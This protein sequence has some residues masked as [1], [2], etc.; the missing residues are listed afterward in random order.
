MNPRKIPGLI[1]ILL[2][3]V[4]SMP[5]VN[6]LC[7]TRVA[8]DR[9]TSFD[10]QIG[11]LDGGQLNS[12]FFRDGLT[13]DIG[14]I[15]G[16]P[17]FDVRLNFT[18]S[19]PVKEPNFTSITFGNFIAYEGNPV[20]IVSYQAWNRT[21]QAWVTINRIPDIDAFMWFNFT[22]RLA[23][24]QDFIGPSGQSWFRLLHES[25]GNPL[26]VLSID[27]SVLEVTYLVD[28]PDDT[29]FYGRVTN[30]IINDKWISANQSAGF[31]NDTYQ[32]ILQ[33]DGIAF[34]DLTT[35]T[36]LDTANRLDLFGTNQ[37]N[38]T[39]AQPNDDLTRLSK[40]EGAAGIGDYDVTFEMNIT[41]ISN[42]LSPALKFSLFTSSQQLNDYNDI[43]DQTTIL[44][45]SLASTTT[46]TTHLVS[47]RSGGIT[48][49][50]GDNALSVGTH[51]YSRMNKSGTLI[52]FYVYSDPA[53]TTLV[54]TAE[55][56]ATGNDTA[57]YWIFPNVLDFNSGG[58][59]QNSGTLSNLD[60]GMGG[61]GFEYENGVIYST[62]LFENVTSSASIFFL[63][64][65][66]GGD[67]SIT[68]DFSEDNSTWTGAKLL[69]NTTFCA[70]NLEGFAL[71]PLFVRFRLN[72]TN[73]LN[74]PLINSYEVIYPAI[75][76][77]DELDIIWLIGLLWLGLV[78]IGYLKEN[79]ILIMFAGF[80]GLILGFLFFVESGMVAIVL[81]LL[82]LYLL[83]EG[84]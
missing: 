54:H 43:T 37:I 38:F 21:G 6:G 67:T 63:N 19:I 62:D 1:L 33:P 57:R 29:P 41:K 2:V 3:L 55:L 8:F 72:T 76:E 44:L 4:P 16:A 49:D 71:N 30:P 52:G 74:T 73:G 32:L 61:G 65:S 20:H 35:W 82:N 47:T 24:I 26:H 25:A 69:P 22:V 50:I 46:Y 34:E 31:I 53:R 18:V 40:D 84:T 59:Q 12:T 15:A 51:Y 81:I 36:L 56:T 10:I 5:T 70:I 64:Y 58:G 27:Y 17:G 7:E 75:L 80:L 14:E 45:R 79:K 28:N 77:V 66:I 60:L 13:L 78:A 23:G 9:M 48:S 39:N 83:Y 42:S 11:D 68:V